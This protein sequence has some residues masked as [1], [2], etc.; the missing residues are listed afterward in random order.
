MSKA[1]Q[2]IRA[3][4]GHPVIDAD[5]HINEFYPGFLDSIEKVGGGDFARRYRE[6]FLPCQ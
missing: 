6:G 2:D 5:A 1:S 4:L 3:Q